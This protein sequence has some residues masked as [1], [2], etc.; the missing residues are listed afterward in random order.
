[1]EML[2]APAPA[3]ATAISSARPQLCTAEA[4]ARPS[5]SSL[6]PGLMKTRA[7]EASACAS[8][9]A[10][11]P[12]STSATRAAFN[13]SP[14]AATGT[15]GEHGAAVGRDTGFCCRMP[16]SA[17][18]DP[19]PRGAA[20]PLSQ[21][22]V[23]ERSLERPG[24]RRNTT[25]FEHQTRFS[26][27]DDLCKSRRARYDDCLLLCHRLEGFQRRDELA[28]FP[29]LARECADIDE[30]IVAGNVLMRHASGEHATV[31]QARGLHPR[32]QIGR[33]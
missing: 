11:R 14:A 20:E 30:R 29:G 32:A 7:A 19:A 33:R 22:R 15:A 31:R 2:F 27:A 10:F 8:C 21:D 17:G 9:Q 6:P 4:A 3:A 23:A 26:I 12:I 16:R 18:N 24:Q 1:M 28:Y 13:S 5:S 25:G